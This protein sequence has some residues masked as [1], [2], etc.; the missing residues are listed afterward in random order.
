ME[1]DFFNK[2]HQVVMQIPQ[3]RVTTYG[4]I[5][6]FL[7]VSKSSR[8]VG[9][10][11]NNSRYS[12]DFIPAH[13]VVNRLGMLTGKAAFSGENTMEELLNSEGVKVESDKVVDFNTLFW[14]PVELLH[15]F[16]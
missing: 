7:G 4:A 16:E 12:I 11:L 10:A 3:G 1:P 8:M 14:D 13:R 15:E 5:A 6:K 2:V 9:W